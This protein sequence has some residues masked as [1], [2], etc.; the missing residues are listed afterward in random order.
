[1]SS[2]MGMGK[3]T[4]GCVAVVHHLDCGMTNFSEEFLR[5]KLKGRVEGMGKKELVEGVGG[6]VF[7]VFTK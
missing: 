6:R 2:I 1:M 7:G 4:V 3:N 5:E